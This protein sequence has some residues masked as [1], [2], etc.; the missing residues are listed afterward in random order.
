MENL[1][2]AMVVAW[3]DRGA[4]N[5]PVALGLALHNDPTFINTLAGTC[6]YHG[7]FYASYKLACITQNTMS[8]IHTKCQL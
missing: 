6:E 2:N 5:N 7:I 4:H 3:P 8:F 1:A